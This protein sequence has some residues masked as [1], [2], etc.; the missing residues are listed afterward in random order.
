MLTYEPLT[1]PGVDVAVC[2]PC[3]AAD[4]FQY[5]GYKFETLCT[6]GGHTVD[7]TSE[8]SL[9][10]RLS[11]G[12]VPVLMAAEVDCA[13]GDKSLS[14]SDTMTPDHFLELKTTM[15]NPKVRLREQQLAQKYP[16]WWIQSFLAGIPTIVLGMRDGNGMLNNVG[17][18]A[19]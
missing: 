18:T 5:Y 6:G 1:R 10:L 7:S 17:A 19:C 16:R 3:V 8:F 13:S 11:I 4:R 15:F 12:M 14:L 9:L 2:A